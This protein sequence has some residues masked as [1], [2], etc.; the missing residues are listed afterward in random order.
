M[1]KESRTGFAER[2]FIEVDGLNMYLLR[3]R[4]DDRLLTWFGVL[5]FEPTFLECRQKVIVAAEWTDAGPDLLWR[6]GGGRGGG[7]R[8]G[9][10]FFSFFALEL[11]SFL[12]HVLFLEKRDAVLVKVSVHVFGFSICVTCP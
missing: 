11:F 12:V 5:R 3:V 6:F 1:S 4:A 2:Y 9:S 10:A 7:Y 8:L